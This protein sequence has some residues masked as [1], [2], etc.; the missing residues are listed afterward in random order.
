[1]TQH[2]P[3][4]PALTIAEA[5][6]PCSDWSLA[7]NQSLVRWQSAH[8]AIRLLRRAAADRSGGPLA[9]PSSRVADA[10]ADDEPPPPA[11]APAAPTPAA[12]AG[13]VARL[14]W[15]LFVR[16]VQSL[17]TRDEWFVALRRRAGGLPSSLAGF[18]PVAI[19]EG[20]VADPML[21]D[22]EGETHLFVEAWDRAAGRGRIGRLDPSSH[23]PAAHQPRLVLETPTHLSYPT[24][25]HWRDQWFLIPENWAGGR[26]DLYRADPFPDHWSYMT[27]LL[28]DVR[29]ADP[30]VH[31]DGGRLWLF[32]TLTE[33]GTNPWGELSLFW[34]D[35]IAGPWQPHPANPIVTDARRARPAGPLFQTEAG[36]IRPAQDCTGAYGRRIVF[37]RVDRLDETGYAETVIGTVEPTGLRGLERTH[38]YSRSAAWEALD[39]RRRTWRVPRPGVRSTTKPPRSPAR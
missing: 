2:Q 14:A 21:V 26:V 18:S 10:L 30:T 3:D 36:L 27:T 38:T 20:Y 25:V 34:A 17:V 33:P 29:A 4:R 32:L 19:A 35:D 24:L 11:D 9:V 8:L 12:V 28:D 23:S 5:I 16:G 13:L 15:R 31:A 37:H 1:V 7:R 39:G 22:A 6:V